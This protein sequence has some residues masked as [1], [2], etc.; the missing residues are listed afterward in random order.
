MKENIEHL[1]SGPQSSE[2]SELLNWVIIAAVSIFAGLVIFFF[3]I[4]LMYFSLDLIAF[5]SMCAISYAIY[6][7]YSG[8]VPEEANVN[9]AESNKAHNEIEKAFENNDEDEENQNNEKE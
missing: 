5:A 7:K 1:V 6:N 2:P 3:W 9:K 4:D 8:E